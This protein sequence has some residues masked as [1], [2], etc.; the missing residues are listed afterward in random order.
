MDGIILYMGKYGSTA[1]YAAWLSEAT[2]FDAV[3]LLKAPRTGLGAYRRVVLG[4]SL[5]CGRLRISGWLH[6]HRAELAKRDV[7]LYSVSG[8]PPESRLLHHMVQANLGFGMMAHINYYP[9]PG[10]LIYHEL[11]AVDRW[12]L[13]GE[14]WLG[15]RLGQYPG[16]YLS[17]TGDF[18]NVSRSQ[19]DPLLQA[20][21]PSSSL[22]R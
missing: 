16:R 1:Q 13:R 21:G 2:G 18:N 12:L 9:L 15:I 6:H 22:S 11:D 14:A 20:L 8:L 3:D 17:A 19:L 5:H 10:R 4:S 7:F